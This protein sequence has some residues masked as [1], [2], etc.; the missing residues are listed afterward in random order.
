M[1]LFRF[2]SAIKPQRFTYIPRYYDP[3]KEEREERIREALGR[4]AQDPDSVK[5]RIRKNFRDRPR[6]KHKAMR[7]S[8]MRS[9]I[10]LVI[11]LITLLLITYILLTRYL[12][13]I[14][15]WLQ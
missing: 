4:S 12:P 14:E 7:A 2:G 3:E 6:R 13:M 11:V 10:T 8:T 5:A 1:A 15:R 9:N